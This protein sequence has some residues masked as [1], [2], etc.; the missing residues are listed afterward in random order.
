[1]HLHNMHIYTWQIKWHLVPTIPV[2]TYFEA[3]T[4]PEYESRTTTKGPNKGRNVHIH[5]HIPAHEIDLLVVIH[6][7]RVMQ[8]AAAVLVVV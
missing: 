7:W 5:A 8:Q 1:M 3:R 4:D 6:A 2:S